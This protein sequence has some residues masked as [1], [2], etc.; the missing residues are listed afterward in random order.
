MSLLYNRSYSSP[1]LLVLYQ[2]FGSHSSKFPGLPLNIPLYA[3]E[4]ILYYKF[5]V[6]L[7]NF[8]SSKII[9]HAQFTKP[10]HFASVQATATLCYTMFFKVFIAPII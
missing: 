7:S 10:L 2:K 8:V 1:I 3:S 9:Y 4:C 6:R 5:H